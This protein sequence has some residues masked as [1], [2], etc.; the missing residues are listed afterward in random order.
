MMVPFSF[1][2]DNHRS[3]D[4]TFPWRWI[5]RDDFRHNSSGFFLWGYVKDM[6]YATSVRDECDLRHNCGGHQFSQV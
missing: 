6:V 1:C 3:L 4:E 2:S 5:R